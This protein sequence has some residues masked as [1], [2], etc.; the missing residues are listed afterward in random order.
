MGLNTYNPCLRKVQFA[1][2]AP[3]S[4]NML[5]ERVTDNQIVVI[6][7]ETNSRGVKVYKIKEKEFIGVYNFNHSPFLGGVGSSL[8]KCDQGLL[9]LFGF[10]KA[11]YTQE[12]GLLCL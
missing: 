12:V 1:G 3:S 2:A 5:V 9:I 6:S 7:G 4:T 11:G 10:T 8:S